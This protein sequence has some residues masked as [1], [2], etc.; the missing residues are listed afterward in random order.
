VIKHRRVDGFGKFVNVAVL[1]GD[2]IKVLGRSYHGRSRL[3]AIT[4]I[5][6]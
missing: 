5:A 2:Q 3:P 6:C 1:Q 4:K